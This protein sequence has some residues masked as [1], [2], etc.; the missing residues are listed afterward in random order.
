MLKQYLR[1]NMQVVDT[2]KVQDRSYFHC[3]IKKIFR[4]FKLTLKVE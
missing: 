2:D 3:E 4:H 1:H